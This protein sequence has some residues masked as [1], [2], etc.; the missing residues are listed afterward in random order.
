MLS[1]IGALEISAENAAFLCVE[2]FGHISALSV[3][4]LREMQRLLKT[5]LDVDGDGDATGP[6]TTP[7]IVVR[8]TAALMAPVEDTESLAGLKQAFQAVI[9]AAQSRHRSPRYACSACVPILRAVV[10]AYRRTVVGI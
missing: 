9:E 7:D 3:D 1:L 5:S 10:L 2:L 8:L 6:S 4:Q